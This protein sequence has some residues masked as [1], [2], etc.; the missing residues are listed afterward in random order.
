M[1]LADELNSA[2]D[3]LLNLEDRVNRDDSLA[4]T[5]R[6]RL[7]QDVGFLL[8]VLDNPLFRE[9]VGIR[10]SLG[11]LGRQIQ[12]HPSLLPEDFDIEN[13]ELLLTLPLPASE[14]ASAASGKLHP[15]DEPGDGTE[16]DGSDSSDESSTSTSE[17]LPDVSIYS[18]SSTPPRV[19]IIRQASPY[20]LTYDVVTDVKHPWPLQKGA[21]WGGI[22]F[23]KNSWDS[24]LQRN[25]WYTVS[26]AYFAL[27]KTLNKV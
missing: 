17:P 8:S 19:F 1:S 13:G 14:Q 2:V 12:Q 5:Q 15:G 7:K 4:K 20:S 3:L 11:Q 16:T 24:V 23:R 26:Q 25:P 18:T 27:H 22:F 21:R 10:D 9:L 6:T